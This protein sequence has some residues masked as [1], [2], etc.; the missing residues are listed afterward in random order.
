MSRKRASRRAGAVGR[1]PQGAGG[2]P[3]A[4]AAGPETTAPDPVAP[5]AALP[6][7]PARSLATPIAW[8]ALLLVLILAGA[9][10]YV[11][12]EQQRREAAL[13]QRV[14]A[15]EAVSGQD[16]TTFDQLRDNLTRRIELELEGI[17]ARQLRAEEDQQRAARR[18]ETLVSETAAETRGD[19]TA[20]LAASVDEGLT[21]QLE[22]V[23]TALT[24]TQ[25]QLDEL[26]IEDREALR[27]AEVQ[28]R[29]RL[30]G[31]RLALGGDVSA[32]IGLLE[33]ADAMLM[34]P[35]SAPGVREA[36]AADLAALRA[37]A[38]V[39]VE[40]IYL[41]IDALLAQVDA[42]VLFET[43]RAAP[44]GPSPPAEGW[45]ERLAQGFRAAMAKLSD[46]VVVSRRDVTVESLMDP[47]YEELVRQ[48]LRLLLEQAQV[49]LLAHREGP[50]RQSLER[51]E[52][53]LTQYFRDG[54]DARRSMVEELRALSGERVAVPLPTLE[55]SLEAIM[56]ARLDDP[57]G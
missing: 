24:A 18:L 51:A 36:L 38:R 1:A 43:P 44:A 3:A 46:Y 32:A 19:V 54:S 7:A 17:A 34:D 45:R 53:W 12:F 29:V 50:Y 22:P 5:A 52:R 25:R 9:A 11:V 16:T 48:N 41:R 49:A 6:P 31:R 28:Y 39:D 4:G 40:G 27:L 14:Q 30:A 56:Q 8:L 10:F 2:S 23:R 57:G 42:L 21:A 20:M 13:L 37:L 55:A 15:L 26:G 47:Q 35:G 33:S